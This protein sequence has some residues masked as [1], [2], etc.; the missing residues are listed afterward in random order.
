LETDHICLGKSD[1]TLKFDVTP[2]DGIIK[3]KPEMKGIKI[4]GTKL[5][6]SASDFPADMFG[7]PIRFTVN[8]QITNCVLTIYQAPQFDFKVPKLPT[9]E[10]KI[11]FIPEGVPE[12]CSF[13][14]LF[15]DG[16]AS[17]ETSP[18]HEYNL[19]EIEDNNVTVALT[20]TAPNGICQQTIVHDI[21]FESKVSLSLNTDHVCLGKS[22][23][24][25]TFVV[26]PTDGKIKAIPEIEGIK[27]KGAKLL[28]LAS[29][30]PADMFGI[31]IHFTV[32]GR[33]STCEL[34]VFQ[35]PQFDFKVPASPTTETKIKFTPVGK[36]EGCKFK[37]D[38]GDG[39]TSEETN[40][41]HEYD[42]SK[43]DGDKVTVTLVVTRSDGY[44]GQ[45]IGHEIVFEI[46]E[47]KCNEKTT[48]LITADHSSINLTA[49]IKEELKISILEP[50]Y[51][52]YSQITKQVNDYLNGL[53][54]SVLNDMF[55]PLLLKTPSILIEI[56]NGDSYTFNEISKLYTL[57]IKLFYNVLRCQPEIT[58]AE[59]NYILTVI[60]SIE[61]GLAQLKER[62][63][64]FDNDGILIA[65]LTEFSKIE[66]LIQTIKDRVNH[67]IVLLN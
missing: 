8:D 66:N 44:C 48:A 53:K 4:E 28:I 26:T 17:T 16:D 55:S 42:L 22:D 52:L 31:P 29:D 3:A 34:T 57:Q 21:V 37:W 33:E 56:Y 30:F 62:K 43:I 38:F 35:A 15:G 41:T 64:K 9:T 18:T 1:E 27:I 5:L 58:S 7:S 46:V 20:I 51:K 19:T 13:L 47:V 60:D 54:N 67:Q 61:N 32:N 59:I 24:E 50:E 12:G 40:P 45:T 11:T 14:W 63:I 65:F 36:P 6:I 23:E 10:T 2:D 49:N 39:A 25:L